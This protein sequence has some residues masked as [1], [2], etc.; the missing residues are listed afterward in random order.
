MFAGRRQIVRV[1]FNVTWP[2]VLPPKR[3]VWQHMNEP[4]TKV[5]EVV[6]QKHQSDFGEVLRR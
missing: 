1:A 6:V 2:L 5:S 3:F 4:C